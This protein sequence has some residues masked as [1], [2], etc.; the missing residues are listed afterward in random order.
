[1]LKLYEQL[2]EEKTKEQ[3]ERELKSREPSGAACTEPKCEGEM[4]FLVPYK[5]HPEYNKLKRA[6]C[7]E[8]GWRGWI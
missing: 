2:Q 8:C 6:I 1:M 5:V 3:K 7:G 4:M